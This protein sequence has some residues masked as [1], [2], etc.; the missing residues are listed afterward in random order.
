M[1]ALSDLGRGNHIQ[2]REGHISAEVQ[3]VRYPRLFMIQN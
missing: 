3:E 2:Q 1:K